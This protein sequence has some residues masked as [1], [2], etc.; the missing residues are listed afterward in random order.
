[1]LCFSFNHIE[2]VI[3]DPKSRVWGFRSVEFQVFTHLQHQQSNS[4]I[5]IIE[6]LSSTFLG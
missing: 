5:G 4:I 6:R 3:K 1:M 2:T